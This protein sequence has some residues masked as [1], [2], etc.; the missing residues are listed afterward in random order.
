MGA[1][2]K[3]RNIAQLDKRQLRRKPPRK[4]IERLVKDVEVGSLDSSTPTPSKEEMFVSHLNRFTPLYCSLL[5][6]K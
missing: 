1:T 4:V 2:T 6:Y 5:S 3:I